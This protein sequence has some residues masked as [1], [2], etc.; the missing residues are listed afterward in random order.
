MLVIHAIKSLVKNTSGHMF[1]SV[2]LEGLEIHTSVLQSKFRV[3]EENIGHSWDCP[4]VSLV[5]RLGMTGSEAFFSPVLSQAL[6]SFKEY[7]SDDSYPPGSW[8]EVW[9][10]AHGHLIFVK[11]L[12]R[13]K[14]FSTI[15]WRTSILR[16]SR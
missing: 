5:Q 13:E 7:R 15:A 4:L 3:S 11:T 2:T 9:S 12:S 16:F 6:K 1:Y 14:T 10:Q 8:Q